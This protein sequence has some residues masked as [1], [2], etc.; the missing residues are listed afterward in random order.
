M[1]GNTFRIEFK[2]LSTIVKKLTVYL[3]DRINLP[4]CKLIGTICCIQLSGNHFWHTKINILLF[5]IKYHLQLF[6]WRSGIKP[7]SE[8]HHQSRSDPAALSHRINSK[9]ALSIY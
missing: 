9:V 1:H 6:D 8:H 3:R 4:L 2:I 7:V 5:L